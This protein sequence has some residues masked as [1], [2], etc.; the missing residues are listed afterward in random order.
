MTRGK[1]RVI[2]HRRR[3]QGRTDYRKR[4]R[5]LKSGRPRLVVRKSLNSMSCQVV[6][7]SPKGDS[8]LVTVT[9]K[10]LGKFGWNGTGGNLPGAYLTGL[11]CGTLAKKQGI[12]SAVLDTGLQTSTRGSRIYGTLKGAL[13]AGLEVP[14]SPEV[15][16]P[17]ERIRG[18][19]IE[20]Y[21][22]SLG[23]KSGISKTFDG[24]RENILKGKAPGKPAKHVV[25][26]APGKRPVVKKPA[27]R[28][29]PA[30]GTRKS[31]AGKK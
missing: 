9:S 30:K 21:A 12:G 20:Q 26:K 23:K 16:P 7:H 8:V 4:L 17:I 29:A 31:R 25:K 10:R 13:D 24:V 22:E 5:L 11:L 2:A 1:V 3:R 27:G 14:H 19:H 15:L 28:K 18:L 6:R